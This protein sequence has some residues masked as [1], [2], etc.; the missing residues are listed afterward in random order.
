[1]SQYNRKINKDGTYPEYHGWTVI[2]KARD[3]MKFVENFISYNNI[4]RQYFSALPANSYHVT[5]NGIW[6]NGKAL[7]KY[8]KRWFKNQSPVEQENIRK[9]TQRPDIYFNPDGFLSGLFYQLHSLCEKYGWN[10]MTLVVE[11][12]YSTGKVIGI[13]FVNTVN[14]NQFNTLKERII[15]ALEKKVDPFPQYHMTL[16]YAFKDIP[17]NQLGVVEN[18]VKILNRLLSGQTITLIKPDVHYYSKMGSY[19]PMGSEHFR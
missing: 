18:N 16:A 4:L 9:N 2:S 1:M 19:V 3:D 15:K 12:V 17:K 7:L 5:V 8:Q 11:E 6:R 10:T 13:R 14:F